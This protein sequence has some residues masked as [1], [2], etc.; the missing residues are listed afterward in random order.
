[1]ASETISTPGSSGAER[2]SGKPAK[3]AAQ[4][5]L[6][7]QVA[8]LREDVAGVGEALKSLAGE[9]A[10]GARK[11]AF[12]L[13]DDVR[14]KGEKYVRQAQETASELE[15]Q[16][17]DVVRAQPIRSILIAAGV[18]YLYARLFRN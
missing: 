7:A 17:T 10:D 5:E 11:Q 18:G 13:R 4:A 6:E 12:A 9:R 15:A 8:R 2:A 3:A 16:L 14:D 1:M